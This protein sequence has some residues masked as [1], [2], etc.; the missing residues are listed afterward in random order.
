MAHKYCA[1]SLSNSLHPKALFSFLDA[2]QANQRSREHI[3]S[4]AIK[5]SLVI[6][7]CF[8]FHHKY[9]LNLHQAISSLAK[10]LIKKGEI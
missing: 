8:T 2:C 7:P 3:L 9:K 6:V 1:A 4:S 5:K 10:L